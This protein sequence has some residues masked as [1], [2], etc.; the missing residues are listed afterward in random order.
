M[1]KPIFL[2][3]LASAAVVSILISAGIFLYVEWDLSRFDTSLKPSSVVS[4]RKETKKEGFGKTTPTAP[5]ESEFSEN[6]QSISKVAEMKPDER[7]FTELD[8][9][10][11]ILE[12]QW[13]E[14]SVSDAELFEDFLG[15]ST[16]VPAMTDQENKTDRKAA[17]AA[18]NE[19]LATDPEY[20]YKQLGT[21]FRSDFGDIPEV[22]ILVESIRKANNGPL[23]VD[24]AL[25]WQEAI[26]RT[27][28]P[29]ESGVASMVL[30]QIESL[31]ELRELERLG[32]EPTKITYRKITI[33]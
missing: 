1:N 12:P 28:P 30:Q 17:V 5:V 24:E 10:E 19:Y 18:Y 32:G 26:L 29:N 8:S 6:Q 21:V 14:P 31:K 16:D 9:S 7:E 33:Q 13:S 20:A 23:T 22:D 27:L 15:D 25:T 2:K 4:E 3:V 11:D